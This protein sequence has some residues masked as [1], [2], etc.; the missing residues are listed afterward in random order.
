LQ[1]VTESEELVMKSEKMVVGALAVALS[2]VA[3]GCAGATVGS[4]GG[5]RAFMSATVPVS[6]P[7]V[8]LPP[9]APQP[10][11][12]TVVVH[13]WARVNHTAFRTTTSTVR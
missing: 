8:T 2:L 11:A 10:Q 13:S 3:A 12:D 9:D 1:T 4:H 5:D 6:V 7:T